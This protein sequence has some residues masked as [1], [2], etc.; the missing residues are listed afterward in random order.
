VNT[1]KILATAA[2]VATVGLA[3]LTLGLGSADAAA[4]GPTP[5]A[6][7]GVT[8]VTPVRVA[9]G[10]ALGSSGT[11]S[12]AIAGHA[13]VPAGATGAVLSVTDA[14]TGAGSTYLS[15][16][17]DGTNEAGQV[18]QVTA[19]AGQTVSTEV[20]VA[21][22][23]DGGVTIYNHVAGSTVYVD[24]LGYTGA[25]P[26]PVTATASTAVS[27]RTDS[28]NHGD[29]AKDAFTRAVTIQRHGAAAVANC[30][31]TATNGITSCYYYTG[32]ITDSGSFQTISGASSPGA[33]VPI[34]GVVAGT[35]SGGSQVEFYASSGAPDGSLVPATFSGD[36]VSSTAWVEQFFPAGTAFG[37][38]GSNEINWA[39]HYG[40]PSFC[41]TWDDDY[42]NGGGA[43]GEG[44]TD[45]S[46]VNHCS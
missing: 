13:G 23:S 16:Y 18:S 38:G 7:S 22:G 46:G 40:A 25:L 36:G 45:I 12:V 26:T 41:Q 42:N 39:Y 6:L 3:S 20:T 44:A 2:A 24:L 11:T 5:T 9:S 43:S 28:G 8:L 33:G 10:V 37:S 15:V 32:S 17:P 27:N 21:L 1:R 19:P 30:G 31:G 14:Y 4:V 34:N 29:W 35:M